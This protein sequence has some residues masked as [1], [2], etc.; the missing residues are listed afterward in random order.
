V[1]FLDEISINYS[2]L[3]MPDANAAPEQNRIQFEKTPENRIKIIHFKNSMK[4]KQTTNNLIKIDINNINLNE[5]FSSSIKK[6]NSDEPPPKLKSKTSRLKVK[7][8]IESK[9]PINSDIEIK[10]KT[11]DNRSDSS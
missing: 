8:K 4:D 9:S 1:N 3:F 10:V 6:L 7:V 2:S 11:H 5:S